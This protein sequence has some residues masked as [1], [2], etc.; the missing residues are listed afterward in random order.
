[1]TFT[2]KAN[3]ERLCATLMNQKG[4]AVPL[5]ELGIDSS[6]KEK[7]LQHPFEINAIGDEIEFMGKMGYDFVK[8]QPSLPL[9]LSQNPIKERVDLQRDIN[10]ILRI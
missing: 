4:D 7:I 5:I 9:N 1:V 3:F 8:I 6:I 10:Y 2:R